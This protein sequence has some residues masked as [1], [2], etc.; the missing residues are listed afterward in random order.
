MWNPIFPVEF[1]LSATI[2]GYHRSLCMNS[3]RGR[4]SIVNPGA[5]LG[6]DPGGSCKGLV[7]KVGGD[8]PNELKL[9]WRREMMSG[10]YNPKWLDAESGDRSIRALTFVANRASDHH[11]GRLTDKEVTRRLA[12]ASGI[13]GSNFDYVRRT[14]ESLEAH[15]IQDAKLWRFLR[16]QGLSDR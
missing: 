3:I 7:M 13:G 1:S 6:L 15:G 5:M 10:A 11:A 9:L 8:V 12:T 2:H 4:G 16:T 14:Q